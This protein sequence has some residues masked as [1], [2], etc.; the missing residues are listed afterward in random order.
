MSGV[1]LGIL[2]ILRILWGD[3]ERWCLSYFLSNLFSCSRDGN[4]GGF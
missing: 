3:L 1:F 4:F 2:R